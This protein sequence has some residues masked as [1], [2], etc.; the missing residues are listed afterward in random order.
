MHIQ[1][2]FRTVDCG[3]GWRGQCNDTMFGR[4]G[5]SFDAPPFFFFLFKLILA[6]LSFG[7]KLKRVA[8]NRLRACRLYRR[9]RERERERARERESCH[10]YLYSSLLFHADTGFVQLNLSVTYYI[11]GCCCRRTVLYPTSLQCRHS[12]QAGLTLASNVDTVGK[13]D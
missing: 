11:Q 2:H 13:Q 4:Y 1:G 5:T 3:D 9:E 12:R 10:T 7:K 6:A 8:D